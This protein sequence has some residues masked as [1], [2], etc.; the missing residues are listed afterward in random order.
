MVQL[1]AVFLNVGDPMLNSYLP[2][3]S[4][5]EDTGTQLQSMVIWCFGHGHL[6]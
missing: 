6:P 5:T 4:P 3:V 1:R 2:V